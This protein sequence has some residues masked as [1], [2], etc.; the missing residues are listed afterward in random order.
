MGEPNE[1]ERLRALDDRI[2]RAKAALNPPK[3]AQ[4][5]HSMAQVGWRM[6]I[7]LVTGL[8]I[9]AAIGYGIDV[10]FDTMPLFLVIF[11]LLGFAAGIQTMLRSA[12]E[13]APKQDRNAPSQ[14]GAEQGD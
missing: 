1:A 4:D 2:A 9:G 13:L 12:R 8:L 10:V 5:H 14:T 6:G 11:T 7:E 3:V